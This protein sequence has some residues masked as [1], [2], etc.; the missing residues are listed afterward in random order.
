MADNGEV[1]LGTLY[2]SSK[3]QQLHWSIAI[4]HL[5]HLN[6]SFLL[7]RGST[8]SVNAVRIVFFIILDSLASTPHLIHTSHYKCLPILCFSFNFSFNSF[9]FIITTIFPDFPRFAPIFPAL[10]QQQISV[11][12][13]SPILLFVLKIFH[14][15]IAEEQ[16]Q[17][18]AVFFLFC[19]LF[20]IN[21]ESLNHSH[22]ISTCT[23][24]RRILWKWK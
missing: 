13:N 4:F 11:H 5:S 23:I 9:M 7:Y 16:K 18:Y 1:C 24:N 15:S 22:F 21:R 12:S 3:L 20:L 6:A 10:L 8:D 17:I 14:I 19:F 2:L